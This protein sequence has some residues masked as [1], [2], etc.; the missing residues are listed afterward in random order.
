MHRRN[1][2]V[3][4]FALDAIGQMPRIG[5][6]GKAAPAV[7]NILVLGERIGDERKQP[8]VGLEGLRQRFGRGLALLLVGI[9]QTDSASAR[10]QA[11]ARSTLKRSPAIVSSNSRFQAADP[12]TDFS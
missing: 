6:I 9:L 5:D 4:Y 12:L 3:D 8:D 2:R 1:Q 10:S 11:P 7:G